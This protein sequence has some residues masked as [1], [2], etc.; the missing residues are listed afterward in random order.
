MDIFSYAP[1]K[2]QQKITEIEKRVTI[3]CILMQLIVRMWAGGEF[4]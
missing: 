2:K 3:F 4:H 1:I